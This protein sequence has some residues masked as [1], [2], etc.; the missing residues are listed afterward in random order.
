MLELSSDPSP[1]PKTISSIHRDLGEQL[2]NLVIESASLQAKARSKLGEGVWWVTEKSLQQ[3]TAWQVANLKAGWFGDRTVA[4]L[5]CGIGGDAV[6]LVK[7]GEVVAVDHDEIVTQMAV[8]NIGRHAMSHATSVRCE[9]VCA[10]DWSADTGIHMDPDRRASERRTTDPEYYQPTWPN[11]IGMIRRADAS[12]IKL[13]PAARVGIHEIPDASRV[14]ISLAGSVREQAV[15]HADAIKLAGVPRGG[16]A[17]YRLR[18]DGT[19]SR[20]MATED[21]ANELPNDPS[22][23]WQS[24]HRP[25]GFMIDPDAAI[26]AAGLTIAFANRFDLKLLGKPS[27]FLTTQD[28]TTLRKYGDGL[29]VVGRVIWSGAADDRKLRRELR[30]RGVYPAT[31]KVRGTDHDPAVLSKRYRCTGERP[32]TLWI[33]RVSRGVYATITEPVAAAESLSL[34]PSSELFPGSC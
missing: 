17:A 3:A 27:G 34:D 7:R 30:S 19:W 21:E 4:D 8:L 9:D 16:R 29:A 20:F 18:R 28:V 25:L 33:S 26:R 13:A 14:W 15:V 31:V 22:R 11:I 6:A 32:V 1:Q 23:L 10:T 12:I 5:C 24:I 2:G